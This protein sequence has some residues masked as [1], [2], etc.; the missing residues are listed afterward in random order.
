MRRKLERLAADCH[1]QR[2]GDGWV[3]SRER[4]EPELREFTR[5]SAYGL[6]ASPDKIM[7]ALRDADSSERPV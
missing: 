2:T 4:V 5:E 1:V 3:V 7:A 6:L